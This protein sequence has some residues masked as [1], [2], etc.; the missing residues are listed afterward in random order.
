MTKHQTPHGDMTAVELIALFED[1]DRHPNALSYE[2]TRCNTVALET[3][4]FIG[5]DLA[6]LASVEKERRQT[7][8]ANLRPAL[9]R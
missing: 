1:A 9:V 7:A 6:S 2:L 4:I 5:D 8:V 3:L